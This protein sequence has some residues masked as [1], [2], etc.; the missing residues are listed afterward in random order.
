MK[1][2][3][4]KYK[5]STIIPIYNVEEYLSETVESVINQTIGFEDNIQLILVNDGSPDKSEDICLDYQKKYPNNVIYVKQENA[6]VSAARNNGLK[7]AAGKY[8]NFLDS[9]DKWSKNA[10]SEIYDFFE[11]NYDDIDLVTGR[12]KYFEKSTNYHPL[13]YVFQKGTRV[14]DI[15]KDYD[16]LHL[17]IT[18]SVIKNEIAKEHI[19]DEKMRYCEDAKYVNEIIIKK[20]KYGVVKEAINYYRRRINGTSATQIKKYK[21]WCF[22][23]PE[24]YLHYLMDYSKKLYGKINYYTQFLIFYEMIGRIQEVKPQNIPDDD[25]LKYRDNMIGII[26]QLDDKI[27]VE[28]NRFNDNYKAY[29]LMLKYDKKIDEIGTLKN[30][31]YVRDNLIIFDLKEKLLTISAMNLKKDTI[32]FIGYVNTY[33]NTDVNV[34]YVYNGKKNKLELYDTDINNGRFFANQFIFSKGFKLSFL[35]SDFKSLGFNLC[36][37]KDKIIHLNPNLSFFSRIDSGC[38]APKKNKLYYVSKGIIKNKPNLFVNRF[39][40]KAKSLL[41][42]I[43]GL[44]IKNI[45]YKTIFELNKKITFKEIWLFGDEFSQGNG[46]ALELFKYVS[47]NNK[48]VR[49]YYVV[50]GNCNNLDSIKKSGEVLFYNSLKY[51]FKYTSASKII[52]TIPNSQSFNPF[53]KSYTYYKNLFD[54]NNYYIVKS[55]YKSDC[56]AVN[57]IYISNHSKIYIGLKNDFELIKNMGYDDND[58]CKTGLPL[59]DKNVDNRQNVILVLPEVRDNIPLSWIKNKKYYNVHFKKT[60]LFRYYNELLKDSEILDLLKKYNYKIRFVVPPQ[61]RANYKDFYKDDRV[62]IV[63]KN[64]DFIDEINKCNLLITDYSNLDINVARMNKPVIYYHFDKE[65]FLETQTYTNM[66]DYKKNGYGN[67]VTD[68]ESLKDELNKNFANEF[69]LEKKYYN[70]ALSNIIVNDNNNCERLYDSLKEEI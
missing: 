62:E 3:N 54:F 32:E 1:K 2:N 4:K 14:I 23:S 37:D 58:I 22:V 51:K 55:L 18:S 16:C 63:Y 46:N 42:M 45:I 41:K 70:R 57:N 27:I 6:G 30:G 36:L 34:E 33:A 24:R 56:R 38:Y 28:S 26:R 25:Y 66:F 12:M 9:D 20:G 49:S 67:V 5:F 64:V 60:E 11:K 39:P 65:L 10:Y 15:E 52:T 21:D 13:D 17:H 19:F 35:K 44:K 53:G 43:K 29:T 7:Y 48:K 47:K 40:Y 69:K 8:I 68:L 31:K 50:N 61:Y 59:F